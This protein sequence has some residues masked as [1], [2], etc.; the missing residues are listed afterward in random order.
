MNRTQ[1]KMSLIYIHGQT[2]ILKAIH[3][4]VVHAFNSLLDFREFD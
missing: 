4:W 1:G 2:S 3:G